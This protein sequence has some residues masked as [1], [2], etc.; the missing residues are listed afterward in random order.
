MNA[1]PPS[2]QRETEEGFLGRGLKRM[3]R[4]DAES[5][6][7]PCHP[8]SSAAKTLPLLVPWRF[9]LRFVAAWRSFF[10]FV[11]IAAGCTSSNSLSD[12]LSTIDLFRTTATPQ[13]VIAA[14]ADLWGDAALKQREG[15]TY[16]F[17]EKLLPP[18]RYVD[19]DFRCYPIALSAPGAA[20]KARLLS[21]GSQINALARQPN[22]AHEAGIPVHV[23]IGTQRVPFG[24]DIR[25]LTGPTY[26]SGYLPI[27]RLDYKQDDQIYRERSFAS[28]DPAFGAAGAVFARFELPLTDDARLELRFEYAGATTA[29]GGI[30]KNSDGQALAVFDQNWEWNTFRNS[31]TSRPRHNRELSVAIFTAPAN[32]ALLP[33][34]SA[35]VFD[36]Q[37][38]LCARTWDNL[39]N[40]GTIIDVP[41]PVVNNA[42]KSLL[43][44]SYMILAGDDLNYSASNQYARKYAHECGESMRSLMLLGHVDDAR[45]TIRPLLTYRRPNIELHDAGFK[46]QLLAHYYFVA[47][48][49]SLINDTR[50]LWQRGVDL[51]VNSRDKSTG[52]LPREKYCSDIETP[53]ISLNTNANCW[54]GLRDMSLVLEDLGEHEQ[55]T[56]LAKLSADYRKVILATIDKT[57]VRTID[58]PFLPIAVGEEDV[59]DPIT[60]SRLGS[61]W[62]LVMPQLLGSG[63]FAPDSEIASDV[64]DF[65]QQ[66][67]GLCMGMM[68]VQSNPGVWVNAQNIDDLY[69]TRYALTLLARDEPDRALVSFYGKLAQGMTR[70][71]FIDG[72]S[73]SIVPLDRFGRQVAL[74]PNSAANA[75]FLLQL[76]HL[77]VQD[78]D[79][80]DDGR[81]DTLRLAFATP[82]AWLA[83]GKT[84]EVKRAPTAFGDVT[85]SIESRLRE[86]EIVARVQ[87]PPRPCNRA[88]LRLRLPRGNKIVYAVANGQPVNLIDS[89]TLE[90]PPA[91][92]IELHAWTK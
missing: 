6:S 80:D 60:G 77:L 48:D 86:Y 73:T 27:V 54:R 78:I 55:A 84:I 37:R 16:A 1:K 65:I 70:D 13:Q 5:F 36:E 61:Y 41:E 38:A 81:P 11:F 85:F 87:L 66:R 49:A 33:T 44:G 25:N 2:R 58:P 46:L 20:T 83:N 12:S 57:M 82:R 59:H 50:E 42:W 31:L 52:L 74:P 18:I 62:N 51:I 71:T 68:R 88:L 17:F 72:E 22:W 29:D 32:P 4:I 10:L 89:E 75:S 14:K 28:V 21:D 9:F 67:G 56:S 63:V 7:D 34:M 23:L 76:R 53:V 3:T 35:S 47:R 8:R 24:A 19:A 40:A 39:I 91:A 69:T 45:Q 15:P 64:L 79:T 92:K 43:I 90:L 26:E 30:V